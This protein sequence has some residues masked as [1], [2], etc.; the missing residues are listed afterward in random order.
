MMNDEEK[1][2]ILIT[3]LV[4][5]R[6]RKEQEI[7]YYEK[8]LHKIQERLGYLYKEKTLTETI[9]AI[10]QTDKVVDIKEHIQAKLENKE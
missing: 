3:D 8:E 10:I 9:L 5:Q 4:D 2:I 6:L 1:K 7:E